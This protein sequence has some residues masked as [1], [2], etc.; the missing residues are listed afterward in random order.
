MSYSRIKFFGVAAAV[1]LTRV[2][3]A[4]NPK[5]GLRNSPHSTVKLTSL[6]RQ[7][8]LIA[9]SLAGQKQNALASQQALRHLITKRGL[10]AR[11]ISLIVRI[12]LGH[13]S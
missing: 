10:I 5:A 13:G 1:F 2:L 4:R 7:A 3:K 9:N 8:S 6:V 11:E 12:R